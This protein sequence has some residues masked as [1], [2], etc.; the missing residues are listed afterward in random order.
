ME[1]Y[2]QDVELDE[3]RFLLQDGMAEV[4][5]EIAK[6]LTAG[7]RKH[8][9]ATWRQ[10][11]TEEHLARAMRHIVKYRMGDRSEN[12]LNHACMRLMMAYAVSMPV[13]ENIYRVSRK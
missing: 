10:I 13:N 4:L 2:E 11:P 1:E 6:G 8:P 5:D 7:N 3:F 12:H 9:G